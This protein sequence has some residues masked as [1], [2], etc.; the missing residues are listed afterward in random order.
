MA[1]GKEKLTV[2]HID[3]RPGKVV[4]E[5]A[6][7]NDVIGK[8]RSAAPGVE[9][10]AAGIFEI[11]FQCSVETLTRNSTLGGDIVHAFGIP[12]HA[13]SEGVSEVICMDFPC[14]S[15]IFSPER[16]KGKDSNQDELRK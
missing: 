4:A 5:L 13:A 12:V 2:R 3:L 10:H 16:A 11:V 14:I 8:R 15:T 7:T 1:R 9:I 6:L